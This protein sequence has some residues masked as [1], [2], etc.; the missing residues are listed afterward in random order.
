M[1]QTIPLSTAHRLVTLE[2]QVTHDEWAHD[3]SQR[4]ERYELVDGVP[5]MSPSERP[6]NRDATSR[7]QLLL[8]L[9]LGPS[10]SYQQDSDVSVRP[11]APLTYR[12]PDFV[13]LRPRADLDHHPLDPRDIS[14]V[15]EALSP[16]T[17]EDDLGRKRLD[18]ASVD[19]PNYL[20]ID[21]ERTPRLT[22][23]TDPAEGDY[24]TEQA[25]ETVTLHI[26]GHDIE[27]NA[28]DIIR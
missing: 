20:I 8:A 2:H 3:W 19:I 18:Y 21:R 12:I 16:A 9:A 28:A 14:L 11:E 17:R 15:A 23:L 10:W 6:R 4:E 13:L 7:L 1:S 24:R 22:L 5:L 26:A 25:G 27:I